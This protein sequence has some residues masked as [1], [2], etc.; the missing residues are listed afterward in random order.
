MGRKSY[1]QK[2]I[3]Q[4]PQFIQMISER[5]D[6]EHWKDEIAWENILPTQEI[7]S[8][9]I[10]TEIETLISENI[11]NDEDYGFKK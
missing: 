2:L 6:D 10:E 11:L 1:K 8:Y 4:Y 7:I 9:N 3:E 5:W